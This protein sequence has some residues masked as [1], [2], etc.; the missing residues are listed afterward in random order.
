[1]ASSANRHNDDH[2]HPFTMM[3]AFEWYTPG[4]GTQWK[5]LA[6]NAARFSDIGITALWLPPP[7]KTASREST[8]YNM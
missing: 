2:P 8:G 4:G 1:M 7:C 5:W 6:E 3:Q